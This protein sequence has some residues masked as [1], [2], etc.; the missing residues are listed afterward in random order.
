M[1]I[2]LTSPIAGAAQTGFTSPSFNWISDRAPAGVTGVQVA[3]VSGSGSMAGVTFHS[4]ASPFTVTFSRPSVLRVLGQ[5]SLSTGIIG[6]VP[7]NVYKAMG[8]KG[9]LPLAGQPLKVG[10]CTITLEIPAGADTADPA[11]IRALISATVGALVQQCAGF[12]DMAIQGV[13]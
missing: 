3:I 10:S 9:L 13:L 8:R 11:N 2:A 4:V 6:N 7:S 1:G 12:G 5:P